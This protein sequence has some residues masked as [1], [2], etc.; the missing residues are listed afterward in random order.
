MSARKKQCWRKS[1]AG[2]DPRHGRRKHGRSLS[3]E[4]VINI[5]NAIYTFSRTTRD[6]ETVVSKFDIIFSISTTGVI[7]F[8]NT[9]YV[10]HWVRHVFKRMHKQE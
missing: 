10:H 3:V 9:C 7:N 5:F 2:R 4:E 6:H 8:Q 1:E